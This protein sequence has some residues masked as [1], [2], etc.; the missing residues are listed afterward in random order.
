MRRKTDKEFEEEFE[1]IIEENYSDE[2][3]DDLENDSITPEEEGFLRGEKKA[4]DY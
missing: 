4:Q 1:E 2:L 3:E